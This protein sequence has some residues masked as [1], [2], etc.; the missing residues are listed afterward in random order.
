MGGE[1]PSESTSSK[2]TAAIFI[3]IVTAILGY[4]ISFVDGHRKDRLEHVNLQIEKLYGPLFALTKANGT[5]WAH[6]QAGWL[7]KREYYF[8]QN[9]K[10]D[11]HDIDNWRRWMQTVFQPM[12]VKMENAIVANSHLLVGDRMP[13][14]FLQMVSHTES[15]KAVIES[16]KNDDS[17]ARYSAE[18]N[19]SPVYYPKR[20][21]LSH[22]LAECIADQYHALKELQH[23]LETKTIY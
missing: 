7:P 12:N 9:I 21:E 13:L 22:D 23:D 3:A 19:V 17:P 1:K 20:P 10:L 18:S 11:N 5:A 14:L 8:D 16:W 4:F 15:Y 6:F 2:I